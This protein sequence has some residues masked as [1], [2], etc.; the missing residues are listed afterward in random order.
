[1]VQPHEQMITWAAL[2]GAKLVGGNSCLNCPPEQWSQRP[3]FSASERKQREK[4]LRWSACPAD[5]YLTELSQRTDS[6]VQTV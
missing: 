4:G 1:M 3:P 5:T 2:W 6:L